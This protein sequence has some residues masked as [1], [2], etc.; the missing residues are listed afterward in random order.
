[1]CKLF[2]ISF[3]FVL[4]NF[5]LFSQNLYFPPVFGEWETR[6]P[7]ELGWCEDNI[8]ELYDYLENTN[9]KSFIL[10]KDGK[11]VLEKYFGTFTKDSLWLWNSAGK[12]M[13][14]MCIGIA[15]SEGL[16]SIEDK[17]SDYLGSGWTSL[18]SN[19]EDEIKIRHQLS[20][21]SGLND[22][23]DVHCSSPSCLTYL[24]EPGTRWSYHNAPY[25]L[26]LSVIENASSQTMNSFVQ[27]RINN[28]IGMYGLYLT[29]GFNR[30]FASTT[31]SMAK[32]GLLLLSEGKWNET[33]VL[34]DNTYFQQM[35]NTSQD[36]NKSYGYLTWLN[37]KS[38]FMIPQSQFI[39][40]GSLLPNAPSDVYAAVGKNG[41]IINVNPSQNIVVIRMGEDDGNSPVP[42]FYN[43]TIWQKINAL[44]C[45]NLL[46]ESKDQSDQTQIYP[47]PAKSFLNIKNAKEIDSI[48]IFDLKGKSIHFQFI[49]NQTLNISS[50][51]KGLYFVKI[52]SMGE[53]K[54][55]KLMIE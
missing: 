48:E 53:S 34:E 16:L 54:I 36:I 21:T 13:T 38:S 33:V 37:G 7:S 26:L 49:D 32:F 31:R 28:K 20:M 8:S 50:F 24:A 23:G 12:V 3:L 52:Y 6:D 47:N 22:T 35:V 41:Q 17:T 4:N 30:I 39:F 55:H 29:I 44:P 40:S 51:E 25:T 18:S 1:M 15:Q 43:D 19:Q 46:L 9:S 10:L 2:I 27:Q 45:S 14:S 5:I 42:T 11:I